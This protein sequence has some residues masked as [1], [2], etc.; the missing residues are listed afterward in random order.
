MADDIPDPFV[1]PMIEH[2]VKVSRL[3]DED[4][5]L[6]LSL[7]LNPMRDKVEQK[8]DTR[9]VEYQRWEDP[10]IEGEFSLRPRRNPLG[11]N[12]GLGDIHPGTAATDL[13][14]L[15]KGSSIHGFRITDTASIIMGNPKDTRGDEGRT[16]TQPFEFRPFTKSAKALKAALAA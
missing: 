13:V 1:E 8:G 10:R 12:F 3:A 2:G 4:G 6:I 9:A 16:I 5:A 7:D 14:N 11:E 15:P